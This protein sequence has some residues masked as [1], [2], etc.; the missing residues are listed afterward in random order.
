M[1]K[2]TEAKRKSLNCCN[3]YMSIMILFKMIPSARSVTDSKSLSLKVFACSDEKMISEIQYSRAIAHLQFINSV[4]KQWST[5]L[6]TQCDQSKNLTQSTSEL[7]RNPSVE[8]IVFLSLCSETST[9][10]TTTQT[11][12]GIGISFIR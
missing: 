7:C 1:A 4:C 8:A 9:K 12:S 10:C 3:T 6:R 2:E 11:K 5:V